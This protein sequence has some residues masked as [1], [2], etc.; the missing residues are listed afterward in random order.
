M[1]EEIWDTTISFLRRP[2]ENGSFD[3]CLL[4]RVNDNL[5]GVISRVGPKETINQNLARRNKEVLGLEIIN[6]I[7]RAEIIFHFQDGVGEEYKSRCHVFFIDDWVGNLDDSQVEW[8]SSDN[9]PWVNLWPS[10]RIWLEPILQ[11][12]EFLAAE[13][14]FNDFELVPVNQLECWIPDESNEVQ[15]N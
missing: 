15:I 3:I 9:M 12:E 6:P 1:I 8:Y 7:Y 5:N 10:T 2:S 11:R 14:K 13:Y 4:D